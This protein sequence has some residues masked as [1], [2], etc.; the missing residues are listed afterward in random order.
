[1]DRQEIEKLA[2]LIKHWSTLTDKNQ[3][4]NLAIQILNRGYVL[5][6]PDAERRE[7]IARIVCEYTIQKNLSDID[8]GTYK[9]TNPWYAKLLQVADSILALAQ[10]PLPL[11][12]K[13]DARD[14]PRLLS[15]L[16][17]LAFVSRRQT[18]RSELKD[19]EHGIPSVDELMAAYEKDNPGDDHAVGLQGVAL[20]IKAWL[21]QPTPATC[22]FCGG[23]DDGAML[24][25]GNS[26]AHAGC[27]IVALNQLIDPEWEQGKEPKKIIGWLKSQPTLPELPEMTDKEIALALEWK[28]TWV[29]IHIG[30]L[31]RL[32]YTQRDLIVDTLK[33]AGY[34]EK[35]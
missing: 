30:D 14:L 18:T 22:A 10:P 16:G 3:S 5:P 23:K 6:L 31:R 2:N 12:S 17:N 32:L 20:F 19:G 21:T 13:V 24:R 1:M 11:L 34:K 15:E 25:V 4:T 35:E 29:N 27:T 26:L 33:K 7:Q 9:R 8:W 28:Q